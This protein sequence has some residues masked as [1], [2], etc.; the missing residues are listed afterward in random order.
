MT[1]STTT[2]NVTKTSATD[3]SW[4]RCGAVALATLMVSGAASC[5]RA[6]DPGSAPA[7][8]NNVSVWGQPN[9]ASPVNCQT[10]PL[11]AGAAET[12]AAS[13]GGYA[14]ARPDHTPTATPPAACPNV[15]VTRFKE[16][17][18]VDPAVVG[19]SRADNGAGDR[20]W[21]FRARLE[22]L[23]GDPAAAGPLAD[24]WLQ[25]WKTLTE[26][27][28]SAAPGAAELA[29]TPRS[30]VDEALRCPWL[31]RSLGTSCTDGCA[32]CGS[33]RLDLEAAPFRL[34]AIVNRTDLAVAG[35]CGA[36]GGELRFVYGALA[37]DGITALPLT[38]IFEYQ[39][40]LPSGETL[41]D[42]AAAWH[43]LGAADLDPSFAARLAPVVARG[44]GRA[45]LHRVLTNENAFGQ[46]D[47]LPWE[48][49]Q[50]VPVQTDA[51]VLRLI[52]VATAQTPRLTLG[53]SPD[54][55]TWIDDNASSVLAG[56]NLLDARFLAASAPL[57]TADFAWRTLARDPAVNAAFNQN[58][59][60]GCH[61]GRTA[62]DVPFQHIAPPAP[63]ADYYGAATGPARISKYLNNP[64]HDDELGRRERALAAL[65][66]GPCGGD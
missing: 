33:P 34:L 50:F 55:G 24:A 58:T 32:T 6:Q 23:A 46:S 65:L 61:G 38:V 41:R 37:A 25:Q 1:A 22:D 52:E 8:R 5:Y 30:G 39:I 35:A 15:V 66:C 18:I 62:D 43:E 12:A 47:G 51:G 56:D 64:G 31:Q 14:D 19:D 42:W 17:L 36:D 11:D 20:P 59:C 60:N 40:A 3:P 48:M 16:L 9:Q 2:T 57:P 27:P 44:L 53:A 49:R 28:A 4:L 7:P 13:T 63:T 26:V 21:S 10:A 45:T 54:L 29:I